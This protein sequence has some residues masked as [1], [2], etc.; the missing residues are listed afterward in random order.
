MQTAEAAIRVTGTAFEVARDD[1]GTR[2]SVAQGSV[3]VT[4]VSTGA[5]LAL[6]AGERTDVSIGARVLARSAGGA[7]TPKWVAQLRGA[8]EA[9]AVGPLLPSITGG[10][11]GGISP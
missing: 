9:A 8:A 7:D 2:V 5:S 1:F 3:E 10:P 11:Q 6:Q 4:A